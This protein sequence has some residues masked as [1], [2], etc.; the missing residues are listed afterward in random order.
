MKKSIGL[1][2]LCC[3]LALAG[4]AA[5]PVVQ[6]AGGAL[7]GYD[8]VTLADEHLPRENIAGGELTAKQDNMLQRRLRERLR[9]YHIRTISGHV[10]NGQAYLVGQ[11]NERADADKAVEVAKSIAG[12]TTINCKFYPMTSVGENR[13]DT[14]LLK[15]A[16]SRLSMSK[17]LE[18]ADLRV[19]VIRGNA[20][21]VG[22]CSDWHQKT[23]AE[24]MVAEI[25]G[26]TDVVNYVVVKNP[27]VTGQE[28]SEIQ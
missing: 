2:I 9:M 27:E 14:A 26:V 19:Q 28:K 13:N 11:V 10:V 24:A 17:R 4:C 8:A 6:V 7:T 20:I 15:E 16:V 25:G 23:A 21:L 1:F 5:Y 18:S 3:A 12:L 22:S